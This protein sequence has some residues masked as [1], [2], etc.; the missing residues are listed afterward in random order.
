MYFKKKIHFEIILTLFKFYKKIRN[1]II[2]LLVCQMIFFFLLLSDL[3]WFPV[4]RQNF[5]NTNSGILAS[6][7]SKDINEPHH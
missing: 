7:Q 1:T 5:V 3:Y 4:M 6:P 2:K